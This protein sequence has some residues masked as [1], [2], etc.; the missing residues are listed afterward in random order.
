MK[1]NIFLLI[2]DYVNE[3]YQ[4]VKE[5]KDQFHLYSKFY[6]PKAISI[7]SEQPLFEELGVILL[8]LHESCISNYVEFPYDLYIAYLTH[9]APLP[10]PRSVMGYSLSDYSTFNYKG[11]MINELPWVCNKFYRDFFLNIYLS[12]ENLMDTLY[13]L[14]AQP[15]SVVVVSKSVQRIITTTEVL[16]TIIFP[17]E[18]NDPY[19]V[20][21]PKSMYNMLGLPFPGLL[22]VPVESGEEREEIIEACFDLTLVVDVDTNELLGK[23]IGT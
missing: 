7:I 13:W 16:R 23:K 4:E 2:E 20:P 1:Y 11:A 14:M 3:I 17:F 12:F 9:I 19:I 10:A 8:Q 5:G 18:Y 22:G 6:I 21:L 15:G